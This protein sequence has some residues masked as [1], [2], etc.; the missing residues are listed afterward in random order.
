MLE[1]T[2]V[3]QFPAEPLLGALG[4]GRQGSGQGG[5]PLGSGKFQTRDFLSS[6]LELCSL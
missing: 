2:G 4:S 6:P 3:Q 1:K 5:F